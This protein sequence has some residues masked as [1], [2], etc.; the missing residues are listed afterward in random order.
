MT[1]LMSAIRQGKPEVVED[2]KKKLHH[3]KQPIPVPSYL[4]AIAAGKLEARKIGPRSHVWSEP[5]VV[6]AA[7]S[8]LEDTEDLLSD[9]KSWLNYMALI[10][11]QCY[12]HLTQKPRSDRRL[13]VVQLAKLINLAL[14]GNTRFHQDRLRRE[15]APNEAT[16][17]QSIQ[18]ARDALESSLI[19]Q[20]PNI[21]AE[22]IITN[23]PATV[24]PVS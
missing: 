5:E 23:T 16:Y 20:H 6:D 21:V 19:M 4:T 18:A 7:A 17:Q 3:F 13:A 15:N 24:I 14:R 8:K 22:R 2:G 10:Q 1:V 11:E 9:S 12:F